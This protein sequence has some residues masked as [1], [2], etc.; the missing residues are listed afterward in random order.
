MKWNVLS[1]IGCFLLTLIYAMKTVLILRQEYGNNYLI[2]A[3][4]LVSIG[5]LLLGIC[6]F[7][8]RFS[9]RFRWLLLILTI[10]V[11]FVVITSTIAE[12][13]LK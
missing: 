11:G 9:K 10:I 3:F 5:S 7:F 8:P 1:A 13:N 12:I 2:I 6:H 4:A